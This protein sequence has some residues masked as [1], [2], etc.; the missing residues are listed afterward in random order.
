MY[1]SGHLSVA[2]FAAALAMSSAARAEDTFYLDPAGVDLIH[3]LGPPPTEDSAAEQAD[4]EVVLAAVNA[5]TDAQI[6]HA[7]DDDQ[8]IV[9]RF[10]DVMGPDFR[11]ESLP[12]T[13][14]LF[15]HVYA[16]G[17]AATLIAKNYFKRRRPF[18]V[19]PDIKIVV[20]Q[21]PDFSYPSNHSTFA[22]EAGILL[23]T[24]VPENAAAIFA[25]SADYAHNR[26][27]AGVHFPSDVEAGRISGSVIDNALL[28]NAHF[29][30]D[31]ASAKAEVRAAL[32][33]NAANG[34]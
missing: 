12:L 23:A 11:T 31:F 7:Q 17:N 33:L 2:L 6:K 3:V 30:A 18:V 27:I 26:V 32:G 28:H 8:R 29:M 4:L 9:F 16:D 21:A 15:Q 10:A 25:R 22:Y 19:D 24:M 1:R 5:R 34:Q 14:H 13:T 20:V